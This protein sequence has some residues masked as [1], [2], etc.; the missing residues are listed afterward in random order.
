MTAFPVAGVNLCEVDLR[1]FLTCVLTI[2]HV[3]LCVYKLYFCCVLIIY[4]CLSH[5]PVAMYF[6]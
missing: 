6:S 1:C 2:C 3:A 4:P 5:V